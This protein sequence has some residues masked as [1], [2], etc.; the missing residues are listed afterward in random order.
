MMI[1]ILHTYLDVQMQHAF[2]LMG[3]AEQWPESAQEHL[4]RVWTHVDVMVA[5]T[6]LPD[7]PI[8][9]LLNHIR[10]LGL[11]LDVLEA[12]TLSDK[13]LWHVQVLRSSLEYITQVVHEYRCPSL[14]VVIDSAL[15]S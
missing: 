3:E 11:E 5:I 1:S 9:E 8:S 13:A 12:F 15:N 2:E 6:P 7:L 4:R 10:D 14:P